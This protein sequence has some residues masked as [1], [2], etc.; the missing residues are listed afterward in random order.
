MSRVRAQPRVDPCSADPCTPG[1]YLVIRKIQCWRSTGLSVAV[2]WAL[3][4]SH[5]DAPRVTG[6]R[7]Q[8]MQFRKVIVVVTACAAATIAANTTRPGVHPRHRAS[9]SDD[10]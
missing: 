1:I 9:L 4:V 2:R 6:I 10:L 7:G 3:R 5:G 8:S